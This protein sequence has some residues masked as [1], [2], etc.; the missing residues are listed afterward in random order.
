MKKMYELFRLPNPKHIRA[1]LCLFAGLVFGLQVNAGPFSSSQSGNSTTFTAK[2]Y[3]RDAAIA[4]ASLAISAGVVYATQPSTLRTLS[5]AVAPLVVRA[6]PVAGAIG[7]AVGTCLGNPACLVVTAAAAALVANELSYQLTTSPE[8]TA[9]VKKADPSA[10]TVAPC[11][12]YQVIPHPDAVGA[13]SSTPTLACLNGV[14]AYQ[15]LIAGGPFAAGYGGNTSSTCTV[16]RTNGYGNFNVG[17]GARTVAPVTA[18]YQPSTVTELS[19]AIGAKTDWPNNSKVTELLEQI[20][21]NTTQAIPLQI[22]SVSGPTSIVGTPTVTTKADGSK[23]T[24]TKTTN[25]GYYG[26]RVD[27]TETVVESA[28]S[29]GG[30]TTTTSTTTKPAETDAACATNANGA[31]CSSTDYDT[32]NDE[33]PKATKNVSFNAENLGFGGGSCPSNV[34]MT[35]ANMAAPITVINW[36]DNCQKITTYAKPMILAMALFAAMMI[37][38]V[39]KPE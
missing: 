31:G 7:S 27:T 11:Y 5:G 18:A 28:T 17:I 3:S 32:P 19:N 30:V 15:T 8:G 21:K 9:I 13:W 37:I 20:V 6:A 25:L 1:A 35:P 36:A 33:I 4:G 10:C 38:F 12:Q 2:D 39:G 26:P 23:T 24:T 34:V 14:A 16:T 29:I 22:P